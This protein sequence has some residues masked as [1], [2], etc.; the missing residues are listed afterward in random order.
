M[1]RLTT[2]TLVSGAFALTTACA[3]GED[4]LSDDEVQELRNGFV[5]DGPLG[6]NPSLPGNGDL[7]IYFAGET[8]VPGCDIW[9][10]SSNTVRNT[11]SPNRDVI[12]TV[13]GDDIRDPDG[14]LLCRRDGNELFERMRDPSNAVVFSVIGPFI[15]DGDLKLNGSILHNLIELKSKL[16]FTFHDKD[17]YDGL[18]LQGDMLVS[19]NVNIRWSSRMR[20]FA[21]ASLIAGECGGP[22]IPPHPDDH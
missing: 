18:V 9:D 17:V 6:E 4:D 22:G 3:E 21:I 15:F 1:R 7:T 8:G 13:V 11:Q 2:L 10:F 5:P 20:K 12:F 16:L 19:A 14:N